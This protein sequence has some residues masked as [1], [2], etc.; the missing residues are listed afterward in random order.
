MNGLLPSILHLLRSDENFR[1]TFHDSFFSNYPQCIA[2]SGGSARYSQR[3]LN[4][5]GD[6]IQSTLQTFELHATP[7]AQAF[8][9]IKSR[10]RGDTR[11]GIELSNLIKQSRLCTQSAL[12]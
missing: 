5:I 4:N 1:M 9:N 6:L 7:E 3:K 12:H 8:I 11:T 10:Q 2:W